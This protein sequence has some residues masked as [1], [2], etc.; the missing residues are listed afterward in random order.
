[1]AWLLFG[2][3]M[4]ELTLKTDPT[5]RLATLPLTGVPIGARAT[6]F[7]D[8]GLASEVACNLTIVA[9][10]V[11]ALAVP[12]LPPELSG[13]WGM[14]RKPGSCSHGLHTRGL[15]ELGILSSWCEYLTLQ[16]VVESIRRGFPVVLSMRFAGVET[17]SVA[18]GFYGS[19][20][21]CSGE[22]GGC[23]EQIDGLFLFDPLDPGA[24]RRVPVE[25][26]SM[27]A[28][29]VKGRTGA[30]RIVSA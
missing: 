18:Y 1:M 2:I 14:S 26:L 10:L 15:E 8:L 3:F 22:P 20:L 9:T 13:I 19:E 4:R 11:P 25:A 21:C 5:C 6:N 29:R 17:F 30:G 28:F 23:Q 16:D 24:E 12:E 27:L 7:N